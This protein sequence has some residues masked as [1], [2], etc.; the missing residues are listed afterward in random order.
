[1]PYPVDKVI[2]WGQEF[3]KYTIFAE[4]KRKK[5]EPKYTVGYSE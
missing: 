3:E 2:N 4:Q 5:K 1:M